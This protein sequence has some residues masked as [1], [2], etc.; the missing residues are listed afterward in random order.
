MV[1]G[2]SFYIR[3]HSG[4]FGKFGNEYLEFEIKDNGLL[5]YTNNTLYKNDGIIK[6]EAVVSL[7]VLNEF[8]RIVQSSEIAMENDEQWPDANING[9]QELE[10]IFENQHI[11][12][13]TNKIGSF[14]D[15]QESKDPNGLL[16]FHYL[17]QDLK[18]FIFSLIGLHFKINPI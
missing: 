12:F 17:V 14:A 5:K 15:I 9:C 16:C 18:S 1:V 4:H 8:K 7:A 10:I 3:Y 11:K 13:V 2:E 6:K